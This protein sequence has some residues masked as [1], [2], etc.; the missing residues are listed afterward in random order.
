MLSLRCLWEHAQP[1][2]SLFPNPLSLVLCFV[3]LPLPPGC[4]GATRPF[5]HWSGPCRACGQMCQEMNNVYCANFATS[6]R[7]WM[8][9]NSVWHGQCCTPRPNDNFFDY[10]ATNE[11]GFDWQPPTAMQSQPG[12]GP[13]HTLLCTIHWANLDSLW[14]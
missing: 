13:G 3:F 5:W 14:R 6:Q 9:C 7:H 1:D 8:P 11:D 12:P 10:V 2:S 4:L